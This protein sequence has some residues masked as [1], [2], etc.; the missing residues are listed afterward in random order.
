[1]RLPRGDEAGT[2]RLTSAALAA[3]LHAPEP[4]TPGAQE[5]AR[6]VLAV[7]TLTDTAE[8]RVAALWHGTVSA[9]PHPNPDPRDV[10]RRRRQR[11]GVL[12]GWLLPAVVLIAVLAYLAW[13]RHAPALAVTGATVHTD[14]AGPACDG[15]ATVVGTLHTNGRAGTVS[16]RWKRSDGT[17]SGVLRQQVAKD[18]HRTDVALRWT[19]DGH[20]TVRATATLE[21]LS[22]DPADAS[23]TFTYACP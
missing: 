2:V 15:T 1:M 17:V 9:D 14:S 20:G 18:A 8:D 7:P 12:G 5:T 3:T 13:Q 21:V 19:F 11:R 23:A 22:P 4:F 10:P 16:Y 6:S